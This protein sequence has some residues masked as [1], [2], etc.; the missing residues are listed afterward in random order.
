MLSAMK[1][2][3]P[4]EEMQAVGAP[5]RITASRVSVPGLDAERHII[6]MER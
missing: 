4:A 2:R 5:W 3:L 1:G 6:V